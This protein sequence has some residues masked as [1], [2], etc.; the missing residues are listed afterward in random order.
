MHK[1]VDLS[2]A[3]T[4]TLERALRTAR[5]RGEQAPAPDCTLVPMDR[6]ADRPFR[7]GKHHYRG[8]ELWR[9]SPR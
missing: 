5:K 3:S 1:T 8:I 2:T 9:S 4:L 7:S 6:V